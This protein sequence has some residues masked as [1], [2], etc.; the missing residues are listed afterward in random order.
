MKE[1][2]VRSLLPHGVELVVEVH[3]R[4]HLQAE[5]AGGDDVVGVPSCQVLGVDVDVVFC[6]ENICNEVVR[7]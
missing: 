2:E 7:K 3:V 4:V 6:T 1:P 5:S